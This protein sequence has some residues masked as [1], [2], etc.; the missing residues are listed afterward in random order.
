MQ[1][2]IEVFDY[3]RSVKKVVPLILLY[4]FLNEK[5]TPQEA[6]SLLHRVELSI[7]FVDDSDQYSSLSDGIGILLPISSGPY[8]TMQ[9]V[10]NDAGIILFEDVP[11]GAYMIH[12]VPEKSFQEAGELLLPTY[13]SN[14]IR[15]HEADTLTLANDVRDTV[16]V[17]RIKVEERATGSAVVGGV[18]QY[19]IHGRY[20]PRGRSVFL[21]SM[22]R[23]EWYYSTTDTLG[24][25]LFTDLPQGMY[26]IE[27]QVPGLLMDTDSYLEFLI[28]ESCAI[29]ELNITAYSDIITVEDLGFPGTGPCP[30]GISSSGIVVYPS[31]ASNELFITPKT[32][33]NFYK[34]YTVKGDLVKEG[35]LEN[36]NQ[37]IDI[38]DL[39]E[40]LYF[41]KTEGQVSAT[42]VIISRGR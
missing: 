37:R 12:F 18:M 10:A 5:A 28:D 21:Y 1:N 34:V 9:V 3:S 14:S 6:D 20:L 19:E 22:D 24:R 16:F 8:D 41:V 36:N 7:G 26:R 4:F 31:P 42:K 13:L 40:G 23:N 32:L 39:Q 15:W 25:F 33:P 11:E 30:T 29:V 38:L 17:N 27:A 35:Y 2:L